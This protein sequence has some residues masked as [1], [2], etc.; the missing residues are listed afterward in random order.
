MARYGIYSH[1]L[2][3]RWLC[4][5]ASNT[6]GAVLT[7]FFSRERIAALEARLAPEQP[8]HLNYYPL[9][10]V[11]ERFPHANGSL[12]PRMEPRPQDDAR[13]LQGLLEGIAAIEKEGYC[14][15]KEF[16]APP[17]N[18]V[19]TVGGGSRN[20]PWR[21]IRERILDIPIRKGFADAAYGTA[22]I[23]L[24]TLQ[25]KPLFDAD[26]PGRGRRD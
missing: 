26:W 11:G 10:A 13:F 14:R 15:L 9:A 6:G 19:F 24:S 12:E 21:R 17:L 20:E 16:G 22:L 7:Q 25:R 8:T 4:G 3:D 5:G 1:R 2:A 18:Q 23:A